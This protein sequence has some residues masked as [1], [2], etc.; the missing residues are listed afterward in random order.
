M[1]WR[2]FQRQQTEEIEEYVILILS[3]PN[4]TFLLQGFLR[5]EACLQKQAATVKVT[6]T[7]SVTKPISFLL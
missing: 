6:Q 1:K 2:H 5:K 7:K 3:T 4:M